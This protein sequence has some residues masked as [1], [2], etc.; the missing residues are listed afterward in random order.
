[1]PP[2]GVTPLAGT[3]EVDTNSTHIIKA[4]YSPKAKD[5]LFPEKTSDA[6]QPDPEIKAIPNNQPAASPI[7]LDVVAFMRG[8]Q[9]IR[10]PSRFNEAQEPER[11]IQRVYEKPP[12]FNNGED[13]ESNVP[14]SSLWKRLQDLTYREN[15]NRNSRPPPAIFIDR[16]CQQISLAHR[17][18]KEFFGPHKIIAAQVPT[19]PEE[20]NAHRVF[21]EKNCNT[22]I[23]SL[24][25]PDDFG[26]RME[27]P[28]WYQEWV[29]GIPTI[30]LTSA[31]RS[32]GLEMK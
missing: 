13:D 14:S 7:S 17:V 10:E 4:C 1:M 31:N 27:D 26:R 20:M 32:R 16:G 9:P 23:L 8:C 25:Q 28:S 2:E 19:T 6:I 30:N 18:A 5:D 29:Q 21:L 22:V 24:I 12:T 15:P 3:R 11:I